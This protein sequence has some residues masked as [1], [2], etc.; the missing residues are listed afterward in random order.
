[1]SWLPAGGGRQR[2]QQQATAAERARAEALHVMDQLAGAKISP[3]FLC[4]HE[5]MWAWVRRQRRQLHLRLCRLQ[6]YK[7]A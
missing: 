2:L 1:M 3:L 7:L 4:P 6:D 5:T